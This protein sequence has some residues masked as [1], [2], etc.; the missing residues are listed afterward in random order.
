[1]SCR[2]GTEDGE[3][4]ALMGWA[5]RAIF[6]RKFPELRMLHAVPNGGE[7]NVVIATKLKAT[8]VK[9]GV[10]DLFLDVARHGMHG[11]RIEM[12]RS[13]IHGGSPSQASDKQLQWR[14]W[15]YDEGFGW[16]LACGWKEARDI[17]VAYLTP[18]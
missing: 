12:K 5:A 14:D 6:H 8:G 1:M 18:S 17:I 13:T 4:I 9:A 10:P 3:Q 15:Y 11:L 2:N 7:R 16:A